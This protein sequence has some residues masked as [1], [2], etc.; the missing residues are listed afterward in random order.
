MEMVG[1]KLM[2]SIAKQTDGGADDKKA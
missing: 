1:I 2:N